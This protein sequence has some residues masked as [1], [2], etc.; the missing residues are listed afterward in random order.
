MVFGLSREFFDGLKRHHGKLPKQRRH[1][2]SAVQESPTSDEESES[3][4]EETA[5]ESEDHLTQHPR[6]LTMRREDE[7]VVGAEVAADVGEVPVGEEEGAELVGPW[8]EPSHP[9]DLVHRGPQLP[10]FRSLRKMMV[11]PI[12]RRQTAPSYHP[13]PMKRIS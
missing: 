6:R 7:A 12:R 5:D 13:K 8:L 11:C 4:A 10:C 3:E 9:F 2:D 1:L